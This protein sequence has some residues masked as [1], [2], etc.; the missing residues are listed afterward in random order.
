MNNLNE[1]LDNNYEGMESNYKNWDKVKFAERVGEYLAE[2]LPESHEFDR[3]LIAILA[4]EMDI[5]VQCYLEVQKS[6][7]I[8]EDAKGNAIGQSIYAR[9]MLKQLG[10]IRRLKKELKL[11]PMDKFRK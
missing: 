10:I 4:T 3:H 11:I 8:I 7:L 2:Y 6:G 5:Y 1:D 9:I